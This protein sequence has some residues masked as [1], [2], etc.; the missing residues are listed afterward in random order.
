ME[1]HIPSA[2]ET[3]TQIRVFQFLLCDRED[4]F[5]EALI[6]FCEYTTEPPA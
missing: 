1:K 5:D 2:S 4:A 3:E 6:F